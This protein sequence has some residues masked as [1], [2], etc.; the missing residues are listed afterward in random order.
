MLSDS[1]R[2]YIHGKLLVIVGNLERPREALSIALPERLRYNLG[3]VGMPSLLIAQAVEICE[4][5]QYEEMPPALSNFLRRLLPGD[6]NVEK[7]I[8]KIYPPPAGSAAADPFDATVLYGRSPF[9]GRQSVRGHLRSL[10][11][12]MPRQPT[13]VIN[14]K[15]TGKSYTNELINHACGQHR[16]VLRCYVPLETTE[17]VSVGPKEL[18]RDIVTLLGGDPATIPVQD[19]NGERWTKELANWVVSTATKTTF[20]CWIILDGFNKN[21]LRADTQSFIVKLANLLTSGVAQRSHRLILMDFDHTI[22]PMQPGS[23]AVD[24]TEA[25]AKSVVEAFVTQLI[26]RSGH[27]LEASPIVAN[28]TQGFPDPI[29]DLPELNRRL[30]EFIAVVS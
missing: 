26:Q 8:A 16:S 22:L 10:L 4:A 2:N 29:E 1:D 11:Q 13:V 18:A 9:L 6:P 7:I 25:I 14:G 12:A 23:I 21:E 30:T 28:L 17:G 24:S 3:L 20:R 27:Q 5:D 15:L 19:T